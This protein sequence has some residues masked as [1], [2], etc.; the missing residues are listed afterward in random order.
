MRAQF[1]F[2]RQLGGLVERYQFVFKNLGRVGLALFECKANHAVLQVPLALLC[3]EE[4]VILIEIAEGLLLDQ[5]LAHLQILSVLDLLRP[6]ISVDVR[7]LA[8]EESFILEVLGL[9]ITP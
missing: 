4:P 9:M 1:L 6:H 3:I 5:F 7:V 8:H 2:G